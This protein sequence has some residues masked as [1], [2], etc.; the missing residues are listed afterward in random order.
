MTL[1]TTPYDTAD[2]LDSEAA[3]VAYLKLAFE[4]G[5]AADIRVALGNVARARGM[6][7]TAQVTGVTR[8]ALHKALS[9]Q[10]NPTLATL[11]GVTKALGYRLKL[12]PL[13]DEAHSKAAE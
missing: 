8:E 3:I 2:Y 5:D 11:L 1:E 4:E 9:P 6:T 13:I 12:V 10:G 7:A